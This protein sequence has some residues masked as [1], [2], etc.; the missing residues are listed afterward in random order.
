MGDRL[1]R[2]FDADKDGKVTKDEFLAG[3]R[4]RF[5]EL[6]LDNDGRITDA[7]LPPMMRGRN[8]LAGGATGSPGGQIGMGFPMLRWLTDADSNKDGVITLDEALAAAEK[9]FV[10]FDR[11]KDGVVDKADLDSMR[12]EMVDY[13]VKRFIHHFGADKEGKVSREQFTKKAAER[14]AQLDVDNNGTIDRNELP[15]RGRW[16]GRE[17]GPGHGWGRGMQGQDGAGPMH[18]GR[19]GPMGPGGGAGQGPGPGPR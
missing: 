3:I 18:G 7:D 2:M 5:A 14:F 12:K 13:R 9:R 17:R 15:G 1:L 11:N 10:G 6:D 8:V 19:M 4:K 16:F